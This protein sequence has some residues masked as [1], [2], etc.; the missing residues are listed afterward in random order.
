MFARWNEGARASIVRSQRI[1]AERGDATL[2]D[3]HVV[4]AL[5]ETPCGAQDVLRGL[6]L[7][8]VLPPREPGGADH[9]GDAHRHREVL[10]AIDVAARVEATVRRDPLITS[11]HLA[12]VT[13]SSTRRMEREDAPANE[14]ALHRA[15]SRSGLDANSVCTALLSHLDEAI[16]ALVALEAE[17]LRSTET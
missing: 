2:A 17:G 4:Q 11:C 6:G 13:L 9:D 15:L 7:T 10:A 3:E 16:P 1:C 5:L 14:Q 12:I 8:S